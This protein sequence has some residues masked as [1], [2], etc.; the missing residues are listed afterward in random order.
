MN[1]TET[2]LE[3]ANI[4]DL[5]ERKGD[6]DKALTGLDY[7][8]AIK[9]LKYLQKIEMTKETLAA[10]LIG[11]TITPLLS[12][13]VPSD[14]SDLEGEVKEIKEI[15]EKLLAEWKKLISKPAIAAPPVKSVP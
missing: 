3:K 12:L 8:T 9:I 11:K 2:K 10:T 4:E 1:G 7:I 15:S 13:K 6:L 5:K 14:R